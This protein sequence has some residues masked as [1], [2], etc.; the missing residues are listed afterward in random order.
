MKTR[1]LALGLATVCL[2]GTLSACSAI[3][4]LGN[5][6]GTVDAFSLKVGDC[7]ISSELKDN[8]TEVP[9]VACTEAHDSEVILIFDIADK[10]FDQTSIDTQAK[11]KCEPALASYV[12]P[13]YATV[14]TQG[15]DWNYFSPTSDSFA[16]G[17]R[18]IDCIAMTIS[19]DS[20][21]T[22]SVKGLG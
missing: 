15:L 19:G 3:S 16:K 11:D 17:D 10:T 1:H 13:N 20:E 18:E 8:F 22:S 2:L 7:I 9:K 21:L 6:P 12:G 5:K 4:S 14:G